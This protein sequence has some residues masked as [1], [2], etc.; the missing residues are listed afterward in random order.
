MIFP[1]T[2]HYP[3]TPIP[4]VNNQSFFQNILSKHWLISSMLAVRL[5]AG[6]SRF[7]GDLKSI[8]ALKNNFVLGQISWQ[9]HVLYEY[10]M[11]W[12]WHHSK[13]AFE[14]VIFFP[15]VV[16]LQLYINTWWSSRVTDLCLMFLW[17]IIQPWFCDRGCPK[18]SK[19][20]LGRVP[21]SSIVSI[22]QGRKAETMEQS[23]SQSCCIASVNCAAFLR[24]H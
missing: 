1:F 3:K 14:E 8:F 11:K 18:V 13:L 20:A 5:E 23:T 9:I 12:T 17:V 15:K 10:W 24:S 2:S 4:V 21:I 6:H 22:G 16:V 19:R 7:Y